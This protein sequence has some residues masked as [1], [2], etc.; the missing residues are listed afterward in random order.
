VI[1]SGTT[2]GSVLR[3]DLEQGVLRS[4]V[5][6]LSSAWVRRH[7]RRHR[8]A[9]AVGRL[10]QRAGLAHGH[11]AH[12]LFVCGVAGNEGSIFVGISP[13]A[14]LELDSATGC[15]IHAFAYSRDVRT[16]IRRKQALAY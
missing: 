2:R 3:W 9:H 14:I 16:C 4:T 15:V 6:L 5:R 7:E 1:T 10:A 12:P 11:V 8:G 13:A